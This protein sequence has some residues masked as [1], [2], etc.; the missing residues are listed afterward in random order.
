MKKN[1]LTKNLK[2]QL[3]RE[4]LH[5]LEQPELER[6][7]GGETLEASCQNCSARSQLTCCTN[8]C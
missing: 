2:L 8:F 3:S 1:K 4:T 5:R 7:A 6:I